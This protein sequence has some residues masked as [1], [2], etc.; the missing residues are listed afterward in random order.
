MAGSNEGRDPVSDEERLYGPNEQWP[1]H[2]CDQW[3]EVL[4]LARSKGWSFKKFTAHR[5]G[6]PLC[7]GGRCVFPTIDKSAT[8]TETFARQK[9]RIIERCRCEP[10]K[11]A[12]LLEQA[13]DCLKKGENLVRAA[14]RLV[15]SICAKHEVEDLLDE[16]DLK[17]DAAERALEQ[18]ERAE[19]RAA[20]AEQEAT[21]RLAEAAYAGEWTPVGVLL[22]G[23]AE[24]EQAEDALAKVTPKAPEKEALVKRLDCLQ[25]DAALARVQVDQM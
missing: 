17:A 21:R 16:V 6:K 12:S 15:A 25:K 23:E 10:A 18:A 22:E 5:F 3:N 2:K 13:A 9:R 4:D 7:P 20:A 14:G 24:I 11:D 1:V 19:G 8:A